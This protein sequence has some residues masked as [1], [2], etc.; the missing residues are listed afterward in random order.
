MKHVNYVNWQQ[1]CR[2]SFA[3]ATAVT[4]LEIGQTSHYPEFKT[5]MDILFLRDQ[6]ISDWCKTSSIRRRFGAT[7]SSSV[8]AGSL[9][10]PPIKS[11]LPNLLAF[12][13]MI[14]LSTP[15]NSKTSG[16][17]HAMLW[18]EAV[19]TDNGFADPLPLKAAWNSWKKPIETNRNLCKGCCVLTCFCKS[20]Y[21]KTSEGFNGCKCP[22]LP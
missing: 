19:P 21:K 8:S 6:Y 11:T 18:R 7:K 15:W 13:R 2:S 9:F 16:K 10:C 1:G 5:S 20:S 4:G 14:F 12:S 3:N 22:K 17:T